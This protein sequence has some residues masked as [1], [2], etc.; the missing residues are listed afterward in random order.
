[1]GIQPDSNMTM[2]VSQTEFALAFAKALGQWKEYPVVGKNE[3]ILDFDSEQDLIDNKDRISM[4]FQTDLFNGLLKAEITDH[5]LNDILIHNSDRKLETPMTVPC[6]VLEHGKLKIDS[7]RI[8]Q[9]LYKGDHY[10]KIEE[11]LVDCHLHLE[12]VAILKDRTGKI[13]ILGHMCGGVMFGDTSEVGKYS[14]KI[15]PNVGDLMDIPVPNG[16]Q[17]QVYRT[18]YEVVQVQECAANES[19]ANPFLRNYIYE[20]NLRAYVASGQVEPEGESKAQ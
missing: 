20:I 6:T 1:M 3:F 18:K 10:T 9:W 14:D 15:I 8:N 16:N 13:R 12:I 4:E 17:P 11:E 7:G 5:T 19:Y 2:W